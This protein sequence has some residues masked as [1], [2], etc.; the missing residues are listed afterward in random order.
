MYTRCRFKSCLRNQQKY[1]EIVRFRGIL[2]SGSRGS[3]RAGG[4]LG[5]D[6]LAGLGA[7]AVVAEEAVGDVAVA[8]PEGVLQILGDVQ[9]HHGHTLIVPHKPFKVAPLAVYHGQ[10][11][12]IR[13]ASDHRIFGKVELLHGCDAVEIAVSLQAGQPAFVGVTERG[14]PRSE[15]VGGGNQHGGQVV[16][17]IQRPGALRQVAER[18]GHG[19]RRGEDLG[20]RGDAVVGCLTAH[21]IAGHVDPFRIQ[22]RVFVEHVFHQKGERLAGDGGDAAVHGRH[23]R[24]ALAPSGE[25][26]TSFVQEHQVVVAAAVVGKQQGHAVLG[27]GVVQHLLRNRLVPVVEVGAFLGHKAAARSLDV[28]EALSVVHKGDLQISHGS[29]AAQNRVTYGEREAG[30]RWSGNVALIG[31]GDGGLK[32]FGAHVGGA[33]QVH[34]HF[35]EGLRHPLARIALGIRSHADLAEGN[36]AAIELGHASAEGVGIGAVG[37]AELARSGVGAVHDIGGNILADLHFFRHLAAVGEVARHAA[38]ELVP[39]AGDEVIHKGGACALAEHVGLAVA[40][41]VL[42]LRGAEALAVNLHVGLLG[43]E[44]VVKRVAT[45][46]I[47]FAVTHVLLGH[48]QHY[49]ADGLVDDVDESEALEIGVSLLLGL[50]AFVR[51]NDERGVVARGGLTAVEL[52]GSVDV[53]KPLRKSHQLWVGDPWRSEH[54]G[55]RRYGRR[56]VRAYLIQ[57]FEC[58]RVSLPVVILQHDIPPIFLVDLRR[59]FAGGPGIANVCRASGN[60]FHGFQINFIILRRAENTTTSLC[61]FSPAHA[62]TYHQVSATVLDADTLTREPEPPK[63][64][65]DHHPKVLLPLDEI[66][67][68]S[69][70]DGIRQVNLLDWLL[71]ART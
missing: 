17:L 40:A 67:S 22:C 51:E 36:T 33:L 5:V 24:E 68:G 53:H 39:G 27:S 21:G 30:N 61:L 47:A 58:R 57:R 31:V 3:G 49:S 62:L 41:A 46:Q 14:I 4:L 66:G 28:T 71:E 8:W 18:H 44:G 7:A 32:I 1:L 25:Q 16:L 29:F 15:V 63:Q 45:L 11:E 59:R 56:R 70:Y 69:N 54:A 48:F 50:I 13:G 52:G 26:N 64:I 23:H 55:E 6:N 19:R 60:H 65:P 38:D 9:A 20:M 35:P 43:V 37:L 10:L 42:A 12:G 34:E 2:R